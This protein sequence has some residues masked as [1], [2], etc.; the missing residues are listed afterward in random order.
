MQENG[1][2]VLSDKLVQERLNV[3][4]LIDNLQESAESAMPH[5]L[6]ETWIPL[7]LTNLQVGFKT[8]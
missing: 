7:E 2:T 3:C 8:L 4:R 5:A 6:D 1:Y